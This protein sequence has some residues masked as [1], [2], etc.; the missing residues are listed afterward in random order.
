MLERISTSGALSEVELSAHQSRPVRRFE[1]DLWLSTIALAKAGWL[2]N[3][4]ECWRLT[5]EGKKAYQ[6]SAGAEDFLAKAAARSSKGWISVNFPQAY[7]FMTRSFDRLSI[8]S[9]LVRR[10]GVRE[11]LSRAFGLTPSWEDVLPMQAPQRFVVPEIKLDNTADLLNHLRSTGV[12]FA[13]GGHA[14]YLSPE[15]L[16][17]TA[18]RFIADNYPS[19]AGLKIVSSPGGIDKS[20]YVRDGYGNGNGESI[21]QKNLV[22]DHS[23]LTLVANLLFAHGVG[24]RLYDLMELQCG[25]TI[26]VAYVMEHVQGHV[27]TIDECDKGVAQIRRLEESGL[28][29]NNMPEGWADEDFKSPR[30]N[31]N[32]FIDNLGRFQ[33]VDFQNF[34]LTGY[35]TFLRNIALNATEKSHFGETSIVRGSKRY[36]YQSIPG[37]NLPAKRNPEARMKVVIDLMNRAGVSLKGRMVLD[38]GCNIGGMMAQY[39]KLGARWCHGWDRDYMTPHTEELLLALGCTRFSTWGGDI[40]QK[41]NLEADLPDF[42]R[43]ALNGC[44]ISF[45]AVRGHVGWLKALGRI[46]WWFLIYEAHE[47]E[48]Q[49]D[50][51][52]HMDDFRKLVNFRVAASATYIDGDSDE[53]IVAILVRENR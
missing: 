3:D 28:I 4:R 51:D 16:G 47:G 35:E 10:I 2:Q 29:L 33:Y 31:R 24:P 6:G 32:A 9:K 12:T 15:A 44:V 13:Q 30:C 26:W 43:P 14:I 49:V 19:N 17:E 25:E 21:L 53:R 18:F 52:K 8:E 46:P 1:E 20:G 42:L 36:L 23:R 22:Y 50:F 38:V 37:L 7:S 41:K 27:P 40:D 48:S 11:L 39:L 34:L 45:L 5:D